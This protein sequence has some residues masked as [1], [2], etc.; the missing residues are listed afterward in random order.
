[1]S[2]PPTGLQSLETDDS[3]ETPLQNPVSPADTSSPQSDVNTEQNAQ[4]QSP[5]P[6]PI[7]IYTREQLVSLSKS[8]LVKVPPDMPDLRSWF[9]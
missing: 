4:K 2:S 7:L 6:R 8:P 9:G 3:T 1:M 5:L